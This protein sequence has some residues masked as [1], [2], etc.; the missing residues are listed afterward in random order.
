MYIQI[1]ARKL[2][3]LS[4]LQPASS[5]VHSYSNEPQVTY[6]SQL[7]LLR[8]TCSKS[9]NKIYRRIGSEK[10][11][12]VKYKEEQSKWGKKRR[13]VVKHLARHFGKIVK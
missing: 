1:S 10:L 13:T 7:L 5:A 8:A 2:P 6:G 3:R 12:A 11:R 4:T 9:S